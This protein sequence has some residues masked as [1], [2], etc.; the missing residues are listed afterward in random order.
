MRGNDNSC[1]IFC[2]NIAIFGTGYVGLVTGVCLAELG[3]NVTCV[4]VD[5]EKIKKL[6]DG[7]T[8]IY[9]PGLENLLKKNSSRL[10][11]T[12]D[13]PKAIKNNEIIFIAVGTPS[14]PDGSANLKYVEEVAQELGK[15][16]TDGKVIVIKST[17]PVG[18]EGLVSDIIKKHYKG[19]FTVVSNPEFLREGSAIND[20]MHPDRIIIGTNDH[21]S[22]DKLDKLYSPLH[23]PIIHTD[24]RSSEIIKYASNA[25]LATKISF[26]NEMANLADKFGANIDFIAK[27]MGYDKRIGFE[28]LNAGLGYGGSCF[29]KDV[30]E[31]IHTA[32]IAGMDMKILEAVDETNT[33]QKLIPVAKLKNKIALKGAT[34]AILGLAFKPD[35]DDLRDA[36]ALTII[37]ALL[38]EGAK[39]K[40]W[41]PVATEPCKKLYPQIEYCKTP[42]E[43]IKGADAAVIV[44]EW[45]ELKS[46]DP[47][48]I[49]KLMKKALIID[50]R[51]VLNKEKALKAGIEYYGIGR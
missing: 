8:P 13:G 51:N 20:F 39:L 40:A 23:A 4:D 49:K 35:T 10:N 50:G 26:I 21:E 32:H 44:T 45:E 11:F 33:K 16:L 25:F 24:I 12:T 48:K 19:D 22:L 15:H 5:S 14:N 17:V 47:S 3:N 41:D 2:M 30:K 28:F 42:D 31:L 46:L 36:S 38:Y 29:P 18:T 7:K 43:T 9:E 27:G 1:I 34:V 6:K 37:D